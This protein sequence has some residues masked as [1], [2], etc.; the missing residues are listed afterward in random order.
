[1][2]KVGRNIWTDK[3][4]RYTK[5]TCAECGKPFFNRKDK[6][7]TFCSGKCHWVSRGRRNHILL[8][9]KDKEILDG[10]LISD[11]SVIKPKSGV[12]SY[13]TVTSAEKEF[14]EFIGSS[15]SFKMRLVRVKPRRIKKYI[16]RGGWE[17]RSRASTTFTGMRPLWYPRGKKIIPAG[18]KL[19]PLSALFWYLGDGSIDTDRAILCTDAFSKSDLQRARQL[20]KNIGV[21]IRISDRNRIIIPNKYVY[22]FFSFIGHNPPIMC[23][24]HKWDTV[25]KKSYFG[26]IC[27][28]C[29]KSFDTNQNHKRWCSE[30][31][32]KKSWKQQHRI[33]S[34]EPTLQE[35]AGN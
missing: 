21:L 28:Y 8:T 6:N 23:Y 19:T 9:R 33:N 15:L 7:Q 14:I 12:N 17:L 2:K 24:A 18:F 35:T 13:F 3:K 20:F 30:R 1:M 31:C 27:A 29:R 22:E 25:V 32:Y 26:R 34:C 11:A 5:R 10:L 4:F 16:S